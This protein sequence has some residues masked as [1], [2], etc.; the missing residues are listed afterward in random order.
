MRLGGNFKVATRSISM[1]G[2]ST[3]TMMENWRRKCRTVG[4]E[5]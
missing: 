1:L 2:G 5:E 3:R 4:M